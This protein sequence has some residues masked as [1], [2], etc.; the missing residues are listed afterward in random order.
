MFISSFI[1]LIV[2]LLLDHVKQ[3]KMSL[4]ADCP[5]VIKVFHIM[6]RDFR[7]LCFLGNI[8]NQPITQEIFLPRNQVSGQLSLETKSGDSSVPQG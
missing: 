4:P 7:W 1:S 8:I 6:K 2:T 5:C 3:R